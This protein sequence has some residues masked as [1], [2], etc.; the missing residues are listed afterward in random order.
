M[1]QLRVTGKLR[2]L[3]G[4]RDSA[5][6][7]PTQDTTTLGAWYIHVFQLGRRKALIFMNER[8][9]LSFILIGARK[10]NTK[11]LYGVFLNG[12]SQYLKTI[13]VRQ[14]K[15]DRI[16]IGYSEC[17]FTKTTSRSTL[18]NLNDLVSLYQWFIWNDGGIENCDLDKIIF[19]INQTPQRRLDWGFSLDVAKELI[20]GHTAM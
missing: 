8:T 9:L 19:R 10:D 7:E 15:I 3:A 13:G 2:K 18:G 14:E 17:C 6:S 4:I 11:N 5:L 1:L 16:V 20:E 12:L